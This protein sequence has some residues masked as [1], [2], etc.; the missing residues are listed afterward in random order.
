MLKRVDLSS[1]WSFVAAAPNL[2][3]VKPVG[4]GALQDQISVLGVAIQAVVKSLLG[5]LLL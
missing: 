3:L 5:L 1:K 4:E 2:D